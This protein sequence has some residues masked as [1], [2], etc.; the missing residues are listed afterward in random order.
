MT[1]RFRTP[2]ADRRYAKP[3]VNARSRLGAAAAAILLAVTSRLASAAIGI[4]M[5]LTAKLRDLQPDEIDL[6]QLV[7]NYGVVQ[8]VLDRASGSDADTAQKLASLIQRGYLRQ[9]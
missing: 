6:V 9:F 8:A 1:W 4:A 5:P 7:H 2:T 3:L